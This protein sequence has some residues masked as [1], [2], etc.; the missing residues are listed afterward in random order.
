MQTKLNYATLSADLVHKTIFTTDNGS[1]L[2]RSSTLAFSFQPVF[3]VAFLSI[4]KTTS[5]KKSGKDLHS[6]IFEISD[7]QREAQNTAF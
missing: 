7:L 5:V 1:S 4:K 6:Q 3:S 2:L